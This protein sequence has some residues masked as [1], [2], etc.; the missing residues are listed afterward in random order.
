MYKKIIVISCIVIVI[1]TGI[2]T[3]EEILKGKKAIETLSE[4]TKKNPTINE[5]TNKVEN[6]VA[7]VQETSTIQNEEK[8]EI[9]ENEKVIDEKIEMSVEEQAKKIAME[10]WGEEDSTVYYSYE[11]NDENE[12]CI[13]CVR[14]QATTKALAWY[15]INLRTKTFEIR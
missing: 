3:A 14:E 1:I 13:V 2:V 15:Y 6:E 12:N 5:I 7:K 4:E 9:K 8:N 11:G 10:D